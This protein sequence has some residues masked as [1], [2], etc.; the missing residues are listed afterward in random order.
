MITENRAP[1]TELLGEFACRRKLKTSEE[2]YDV[3]GSHPLHRMTAPGF[4]L[5]TSEAAG[6]HVSTAPL[7][8]PQP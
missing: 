7:Q 1:N 6:A 3:G 8:Q 4:E 2:T 5:G